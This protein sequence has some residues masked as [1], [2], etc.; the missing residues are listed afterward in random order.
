MIGTAGRVLAAVSAVLAGLAVWQGTDLAAALPFGIAAIAAAALVVL[1]PALGPLAGRDP[2]PTTPASG[3]DL[4]RV[5]L[6]LHTGPA[7]R[8]S[9]VALLDRCERARTNSTLPNRREGEVDRL[10]RLPHGEFLSYVRQRLDELE[11]RT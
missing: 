7:G 11:G 5:A 2:T 4:D 10:A 3:V 1:L 8:A 9:I 6:A